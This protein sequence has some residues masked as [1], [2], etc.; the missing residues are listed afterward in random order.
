MDNF[1]GLRWLF[2]NSAIERATVETCA[3]LLTFVDHR[4]EHL[5]VLARLSILSNS[6]QAAVTFGLAEKN[7]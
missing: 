6:F 1:E 4:L 7:S 5:K 2:L 3:H